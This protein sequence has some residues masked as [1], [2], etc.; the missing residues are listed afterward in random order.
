MSIFLYVI[1]VLTR[2]STQDRIP[3][4]RLVLADL[5]SR[6]RALLVMGSNT[7][8][9]CHINGLART[10]HPL[11]TTTDPYQP[12]PTSIGRPQPF[13]ILSYPHP[14]PFQAFLHGVSAVSGVF[15][16]GRFS[17]ECW[18]GSR[19]GE[20]EG[21]SQRVLIP[22]GRTRAHWKALAKAHTIVQ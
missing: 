2:S 16:G 9:K 1:L 5:R 13:Q 14:Q 11:P 6:D 3:P 12:P 4:N 19:S 20:A 15:F 8:Q 10:Q 21:I 17:T 18:R 7:A 22:R